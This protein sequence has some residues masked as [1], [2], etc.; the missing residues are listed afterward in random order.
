MPALSFSFLFR[1]IAVGKQIRIPVVALIW[2]SVSLIAVLAKVL[3]APMNNYFVYQGVFWHTLHQTNL[4]QPYPAEYYDTNYYGPVFS[5]VIAPFALFP[6]RLGCILWCMA[7]AGFLYYAIMKLP[8]SYQQRMGVLLIS[9]LELITSLQNVQF[10]PMLTAWIILAFVL[11]HKEKEWAATLFIA[12]GFLVKLYGIIALVT[13]LFSRRKWQFVLWFAVW[14]VVLLCLPMLISSPRFV[15]QSYMDWFEAITSKNEENIA[16]TLS[17][18]PQDISVPGM[19][20]RIFKQ[21]YFSGLWALVPAAVLYLLPLLRWRVYGAKM[22]QLLYLSLSLIMVVIFS[23]SAESP[24]YVIAMAGV[25]VWFV[26]QPTPPSR[27]AIAALVFA[28]L[29][30]SLSP[31]DLF[32][33]FIRT[34]YVTRYSLKALPCLVVW[35]VI[36]WQLLQRPFVVND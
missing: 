19:V 7:N 9:F 6:W 33:R 14:M 35:L 26:V 3:H 18:G 34:N 22:Y 1:R 28:L 15:V 11:V 25:G 27:R 16:Q 36:V 13:F 31:T 8:L 30:T 12:A 20:R 21:P 5:F 23:S 24:T 17:G 10:N 29:L 2:F 4:Y 32:P